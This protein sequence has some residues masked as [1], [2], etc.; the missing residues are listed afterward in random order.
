[1]ARIKT[2]EQ[3]TTLN[4]LDKF[5]GTDSA[6]DGT[7]NF[8]IQSVVDLI[9][10]GGLIPQP[11]SIPYN[12]GVYDEDV[13]APEGILTLGTGNPAAGNFSDITEILLSKTDKNGNDVESFIDSLTN[14]NIKISPRGQSKSPFGVFKITAIADVDDNNDQYIKLTLT[15]ITLVGQ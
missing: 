8:T 1:M 4:V 3:D 11:I 12:F 13:A 5:L 6:T 14:Y 10:E 2:Y 9:V 15:H 7:K